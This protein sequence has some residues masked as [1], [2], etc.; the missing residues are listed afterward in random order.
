MPDDK[1]VNIALD[2]IAEV[3]WKGKF[4]GCP[5]CPWCTAP[6]DLFGRGIDS[7]HNPRCHAAQFMG[8][9]MREQD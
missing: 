5:T 1:D 8:W 9:P 3:Q 7:L 2:L 4:T 6:E